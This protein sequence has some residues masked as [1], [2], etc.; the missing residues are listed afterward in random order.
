MSEVK[1]YACDLWLGGIPCEDVLGN[2]VLAADYDSLFNTPEEAYE[3]YCV[4]AKQHYGEFAFIG[5]EKGTVK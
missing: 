2:F 1:R 3:A 5:A 4:A